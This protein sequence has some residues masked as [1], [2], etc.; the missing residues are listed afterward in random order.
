M[1]VWRTGAFVACALALAAG[2]VVA[3]P[4]L[5]SVQVREGQARETP[6]FLGRVVA[7]LG[8]GAQ[9]QPKEEK[10]GW[11]RVGLPGGAE[12]WMHMSA[13]TPKKIV[14]RSGAADAQKAASADEIALAGKGFNAQVEQQY[15]ARHREADF[16]WIDR[17]E[18][19]G[20]PPEQLVAFLRQGE[21]NPRGGGK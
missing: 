9:V 10:A 15:R 21:V 11:A 14:F 17:M 19:F 12:G 1:S 20:V 16:T 18:K 7:T 2:V 8:Y 3:A 13:L 5:M 6:S 4:K